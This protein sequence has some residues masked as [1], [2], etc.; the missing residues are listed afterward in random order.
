MIDVSKSSRINAVFGVVGR[1]KGFSQ[2]RQKEG[3]PPTQAVET[4][5]ICVISRLFQMLRL[6]CPRVFL[7]SM[8]SENRFQELFP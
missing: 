6:C 4:S 3:S 2:N 5:M 1:K 7:P 8:V